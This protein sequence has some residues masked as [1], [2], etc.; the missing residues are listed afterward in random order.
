MRVDSDIEL[1]DIEE[2][3]LNI[4]PI[5]AAGRLTA[6]AR[7][8]LIAYGDGYSVCDYCLK[9]FRLDYIDKPPIARFYRQLAEFVGM[10]AARVLPGARRGF[11][12]VANTLLGKDDIALVTAVSHYSLILAIEATGA[13]WF[14]IPLNNENRV[15]PDSTEAKIREIQLTTGKSPKLIAVPHIDYEFGNEH[16]VA[17]IAAVAHLHNI[18]FLYN[19]AYTVGVMPVDGAS[20]GADF[21][22]GSGHKSMASPAPTGVLATTRSF[23]DEVFRTTTGKGDITGR[24]F[25]IKETELLGCT[26]MGAPL[27]AMMASFPTVKQRV[28]Q[29]NEEI[30]RTNWFISQLLRIEGVHVLSEMPRKHTLTRLDTSDSFGVVAKSHRKRGYF[31][32]KE[33]QKRNIVGVKRGATR[34]WKL[35]TYGLNWEQIKYVAKAFLEIAH[36]NGLKIK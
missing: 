34:Q 5:Q 25:G 6:E 2:L 3:F 8:A 28:D 19:G 36:E 18:P 4:S 33:L 7:K 27:V 23:S 13:S 11:R 16:D 15:T 29:W 24:T 26:V 20:I 30:K 14:E 35:N 1:R 12:A 21:V 32:Y 22:V 17:S 9:P 31:L 10:D